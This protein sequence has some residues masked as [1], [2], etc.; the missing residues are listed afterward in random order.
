[1]IAIKDEKGRYVT[2]PFYG[3]GRLKDAMPF[4]SQLDARVTK[5]ALDALYG[6]RKQFKIVE[7]SQ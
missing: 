4:Q 3:F 5:C 1:M 2:F 6:A 7:V